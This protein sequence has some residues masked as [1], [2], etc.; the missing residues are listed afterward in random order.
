MPSLFLGC[1]LLTGQ[2]FNRAPRFE[3]VDPSNQ[4]VSIFKTQN[5][6]STTGSTQLTRSSKEQ[7]STRK[8]SLMD[9]ATPDSIVSAFCRAILKRIIPLDFWGNTDVRDHN[10][11]VF[12]GKVHS[13]VRMRRFESL[14]LHE[15]SQGIKV[16]RSGRLL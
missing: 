11:S 7:L 6:R 15:I 2:S 10:E 1:Y 3:A 9:H 13:F 16:C 4:E 14:S 5:P 8:P 12:Y